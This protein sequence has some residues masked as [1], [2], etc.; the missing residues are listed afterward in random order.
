MGEETI[1]DRSQDTVK[2]LNYGFNTYKVNLIKEKNATVGRIKIEGGKKDYAD[3]I[4]KEDATQL[5]KT[6]DKV[7]NYRFEMKTVK[8]KAPIKRGDTVGKIK[9]FDEKNKLI[10]E[11]EVT[12]KE[13]IA[14]ANIWDCFVKNLKTALSFN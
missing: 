13:D 9:I 3:V 8:V 14:K 12:V 11:V 4:L 1:E 7:A 10:N 6:T 5:L 2:L